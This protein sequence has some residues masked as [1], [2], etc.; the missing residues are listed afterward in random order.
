MMHVVGRYGHVWQRQ[1]E[2]I[3]LAR[4]SSASHILPLFLQATDM[5]STRLGLGS[6]VDRFKKVHSSL[7]Q[8]CLRKRDRS[9]A[10]R[11]ETALPLL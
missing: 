11:C 3:H 1:T 9:I 4:G 10:C 5:G 6:A 8:F 7:Y 2:L